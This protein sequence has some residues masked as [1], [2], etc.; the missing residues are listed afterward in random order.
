MAT[1]SAATWD[2]TPPAISACTLAL[3]SLTSS[4]SGSLPP[5]SLSPEWK[6]G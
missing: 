1:S 6:R 2:D 3:I 4:I 5:K